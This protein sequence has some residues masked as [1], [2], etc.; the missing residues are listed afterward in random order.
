MLALC[1]L[2]LAYAIRVR[3]VQMQQFDTACSVLSALQQGALRTARLRCDQALAAM[4]DGP[5]YTA[6]QSTRRVLDELDR[7]HT[8]PLTADTLGRLATRLEQFAE[9]WNRVRNDTTRQL[10]RHIPRTC[11]QMV[12]RQIARE[13]QGAQASGDAKTLER[14]DALINSPYLAQWTPKG[15]IA[16]WRSALVELRRQ[17]QSRA[18]TESVQAAVENLMQARSP[19]ELQEAVRNVV[20]ATE[21]LA[22]SPVGLDHALARLADRCRLVVRSKPSPNRLPPITVP[23]AILKQAAAAARNPSRVPILILL[24]C[25]LIELDS[26]PWS[27]R[28]LLRPLPSQAAAGLVAKGWQPKADVIALDAHGHRTVHFP[29]PILAAGIDPAGEALVAVGQS[30]IAY[31]LRLRDEAID[32]C[33]AVLP[34]AAEPAIGASVT[35]A[36]GVAVIVRRLVNGDSIVEVIDSQNPSTRASARLREER[37]LTPAVPAQGATYV[38]T[39]NGMIYGFRWSA[40]KKLTAAGA[41]QGCREKPPHAPVLA[42]ACGDTLAFACH[43]TVHLFV[44]EPLRRRISPRWKTRLDEHGWPLTGLRCDG[45]RRLF[46]VAAVAGGDAVRIDVLEIGSGAVL[47]S[48]QVGIPLATAWWVDDRWVGAD[49]VEA[50]LWEINQ[51]GLVQELAELPSASLPTPLKDAPVVGCA[52]G[53]LVLERLETWSTY[54]RQLPGEGIL[55]SRTMVQCPRR[56]FGTG[57]AGGGRVAAAVGLLGDRSVVVVP[58]ERHLAELRSASLPELPAGVSELFAVTSEQ[59][60]LLIGLGGQRELWLMEPVAEGR[61]RWLRLR[62]ATALPEPLAEMARSGSGAVLVRFQSGRLCVLGPQSP[63]PRVGPAT[64]FEALSWAV[65]GAHLWAID[66]RGVL[67]VL[68]L[69][70]EAFAEAAAVP[71]PG[72]HQVLLR[73]FGAAEPL[74]VWREGSD[75]VVASRERDRIEPLVRVPARPMAA[76]WASPK[77]LA[78]LLPGGAVVQIIRSASHR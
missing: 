29:E 15:E 70:G 18:L 61:Q 57:A 4:P 21:P 78:L 49:L 71:V 74:V 19:S 13:L 36:D 50:R 11:R 24:R 16:R 17:L 58:L 43:G 5:L 28:H 68:Q 60:G 3:L 64:A 2:P 33:G 37:A 14:L 8:A 1:A 35:A 59:H 73:P 72:Q 26:H 44:P 41:A 10:A 30:G 76:A 39:S 22:A 75:W 42:R 69:R 46:V 67:H 12:R 20:R 63:A 34:P 23:V 77:K 52:D 55:W 51:D 6:L 65:C 66:R 62:G 31:T 47:E 25:G 53:V 32:R 48:V 56:W 9:A 38:A 45:D 54:R 40:G 7:L 27:V